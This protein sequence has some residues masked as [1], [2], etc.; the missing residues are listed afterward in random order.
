LTLSGAT[1]LAGVIGWPVRH[2]LS[3]VI[4]NAG[5]AE[6]GLDWAYVAF[7]VAPAGLAAAL[8][9]AAAL[10][11]RGLSVTMPHKDGVAA[12]VDALT[13]PAAALAAVNTVTFGPEG[14]IGDNTDG[15]GFVDALAVAGWSPEGR[16]CAVL[17][18]GGAARA[19]ILALGSAGAAGVVVINRT[20]ERASVAAA[21]AGPAGRVGGVEEVA[22]V[23]LVVNAT[24]VGMAGTPAAGQVAVEP[25]LLRAGQ[26]VVD[27]VYHPVDTPLLAAARDRG[28][29]A[30]DGVGMLVHQAARQFSAWTG[31][32]APVA[33]MAA[34]ARRAIEG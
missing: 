17:G 10:G 12:L 27:L 30:L 13:A 19:V 33:A 29:I 9:G 1:Q 21:L 2:S 8:A 20:P 15:G 22:G 34:A 4:H 31:R 26:V 11:V 7:E 5:F 18:A 25:S 6:A 3:P 23:D 32:E 14:A 16:R 24:S 28:A